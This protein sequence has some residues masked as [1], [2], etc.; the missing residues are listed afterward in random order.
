MFV[1][2]SENRFSRGTATSAHDILRDVKTDTICSDYFLN[3]FVEFKEHA[4]FLAANAIRTGIPVKMP[5]P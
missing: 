2:G 1:A 3:F 4:K 5:Y